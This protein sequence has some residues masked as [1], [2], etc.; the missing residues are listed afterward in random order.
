MHNKPEFLMLVGLPGSGKST[1]IKKYFNQNLRVHSS[2]A[3]RAELSGDENNQNI[4]AKVFE[5]L[6]NRVKEDL[7]NGISC[8]YDATNISYKRRKAFLDELK[9]R[10]G[11]A[12]ALISSS[13]SPA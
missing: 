9:S 11:K 1:Y 2:D 10:R 7:R 8:V 13:N 5:V 12:F 4:N 6:H 3:I